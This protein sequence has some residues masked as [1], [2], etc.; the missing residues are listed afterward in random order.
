MPTP[1]QLA[2]ITPQDGDGS[3]Q[4]VNE[5][6]TTQTDWPDGTVRIDYGDG[7]YMVTFP[8]GAVLNG[9]VDGARTLNDVNGGALDLITGGPLETPVDPP[10]AYGADK[11]REFLEGLDILDSPDD[12]EQY[13]GAFKDALEGIENPV[14][15]F[16][17]P[18]QV[19]LA[20]WHALETKQRGCY[21]RGWAY[22]VMY[23]VTGLGAPPEPVFTG[24]IQQDA[25]IAELDLQAWREGVA[26][27]QEQIDGDAAFRNRL[28]FRFVVDNRAPLATLKALYTAACDATDDWQLKKTY[29]DILGWPEPTGA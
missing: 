8:D 3:S 1:E 11:V 22:A 26:A 4:S 16:K 19:A 17:I 7:S 21:M 14:E 15:W 9:Y 5:D 12:A 20:G 13:V 27:G 18:L 28:M 29:I 6:G 25:E 2:A 10:P 23:R 24:G